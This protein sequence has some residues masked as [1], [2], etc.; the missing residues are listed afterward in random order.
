MSTSNLPPHPEASPAACTIS[1]LP[2]SGPA[3]GSYRQIV[4]LAGPLILSSTGLMIMQSVD[5]L[6]LAQ[7]STNAV[8]AVV[9]A[10]MASHL[11]IS[12]FLGVAAYA[13]TFVAQYVGSGRPERAA[14]A[15]WQGIYFSLLTGGL[16][17]ATAWLADPLFAFVG[18]ARE[19][20]GLEAAVFR[21][22]CWCGPF[23]LLGGALSGFF[24]GRGSTKTLMVVQLLGFLLNVVLDWAM[25]FGRMGLPEM[26]IAGA[27][28][29]TGISQ[30]VIAALL[31]WLFLLP[32]FRREFG[33]WRERAFD[34]ELFR[35]LM[36]YGFPS[37]F[38]W[39]VECLAW[40][41]FLFF[42]GRMGPDAMAA[43]S[44]AWRI[45][46]I[47]FFPLIGLAQAI[48][49]VVGQAQGANKPDLAA[50]CTWRGLIL[51][52]GWMLFGAACFV[53]FPRPLIECFRDPSVSAEAFAPVLESGVV[54]LR[55]VALYCLLDGLNFVFLSA[56]Q[57]AGDTHWTFWTGCVV[58]FGFLL[59]LWWLDRTGAGLVSFWQAATVCVMA[60]ALV[61]MARFHAGHWKSKRVVEAAPDLPAAS[62]T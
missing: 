21:I 59:V 15:V 52:E 14:A 53:L 2:T 1:D 33:T 43:S 31:A 16:V 9:P 19:L 26:G 39:V 60:Q 41:F 30:A 47:A 38:R 18:H 50:R 45:N 46:G 3:S 28:W 27:A 24:T 42:V 10:S 62:A 23:A 5:A 51:A 56:L 54:V 22:T 57:G 40:T 29:A 6:F 37:G 49:V 34:A 44:I 36:V 48:A 20:Q 58:N 25:I 13:S 8:A 55:Y 61:W 4:T 35:R 32:E 11:V 7:Y 12:L 17:F